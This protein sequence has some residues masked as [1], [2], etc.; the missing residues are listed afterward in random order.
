M[1][2]GLDVAV[3]IIVITG[4]SIDRDDLRYSGQMPLL[5]IQVADE[6]VP[7]QKIRS[8]AER[9]A[10]RHLAIDIPALWAAPTTTAADRKEI[11]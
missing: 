3:D 4:R 8:D 9:E 1:F 10:I 11:I 6:L 7:I 2:D 5:D